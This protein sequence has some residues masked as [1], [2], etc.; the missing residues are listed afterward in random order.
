M[1]AKAFLST[2]RTKVRARETAKT[3]AKS[4]H[5]RETTGGQGVHREVESE[6]LEE[7]YRAVVKGATPRTNRSAKDGARSSRHYD[8]EG[9]LI[10]PSYQGVCE[11]H[12]TEDLVV[13]RQANWC[14]IGGASP[15]LRKTN[16][17][18]I[19]SSRAFVPVRVQTKRRQRCVWA[20][21]MSTERIIVRDAEAFT[22]VEGNTFF[23]ASG[24][25]QEGPAVS[26]NPGTHVCN[27]PKNP[28][29]HVCNAPGPGRSLHC[30][31]PR[32]G[33]PKRRL[34]ADQ[35]MH[36]GEKSDAMIVALKPANKAWVP[37]WR[38]WWSEAS[39]PRGNREALHV[40]DTEPDSAC[41]MGWTGYGCGSACRLANVMRA[42]A[43]QGRSRMR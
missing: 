12:G 6:G 21:L 34:N 10:H 37:T 32:G 1:T 38:S 39:R 14:F 36:G 24:E 17:L 3:G 4:G 28:G 5:C 35:R 23:A 30:P 11:R 8:G 41:P 26:K 2:R 22:S 13:V 7:Q 20:G 43:T 16:H 42:G 33:P 18:R 40:P 25:A 27:A 15:P 19:P 29:T 9:V 31:T